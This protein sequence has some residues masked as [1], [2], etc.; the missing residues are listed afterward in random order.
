MLKMKLITIKMLM[1]FTQYFFLILDVFLVRN[2]HTEF[3][4]ISD[5]RGAFSPLISFIHMVKNQ[6]LRGNKTNF[7]MKDFT[8]GLALKQKA[9]REWPIKL[10]R[11]VCVCLPRVNT[12]LRDF[13][14]VTNFLPTHFYYYHGSKIELETKMFK[15]RK[16]HYHG[17]IS[18]VKMRIPPKSRMHSYEERQTFHVLCA[19]D[20]NWKF[21]TLA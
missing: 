5:L 8:A 7:H 10:P 4:I 21:S 14:L 16:Q 6:N 19:T 13:L 12:F 2:R 11:V 18:M 17:L 15:G 20:V 1:P 3:N 9:T